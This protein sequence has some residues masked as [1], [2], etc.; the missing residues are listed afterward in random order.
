MYRTNGSNSLWELTTHDDKFRTALGVLLFLIIT[1]K[2]LFELKMDE[3]IL[4]YKSIEK[5]SVYIIVDHSKLETA[6]QG[7]LPWYYLS[8]Q[9][10]N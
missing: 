1:E 2:S 6:N 4:S 3:F 9:A 8:T 10:F 5:L 7:N